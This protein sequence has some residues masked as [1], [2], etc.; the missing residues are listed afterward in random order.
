M[1]EVAQSCP[2]L[3]DPWTVAYQAPGSMGFSRQEYWSGSSFPSPEDLPDPGIKPRCP[4]LQVAS[5]PSEPPGE[6]SDKSF[7]ERQIL[8]DITYVWKLKKVRLKNRE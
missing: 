8:E 6:P 7:R 2:S 5:L 1:S 3:C 4:S